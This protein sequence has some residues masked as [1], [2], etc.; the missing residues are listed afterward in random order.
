MVGMRIW[1]E[2]RGDYAIDAGSRHHL[3][4]SPSHATCDAE[5]AATAICSAC[6]WDAAVAPSLIEYRP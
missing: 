1:W 4:G 6:L 3:V 5:A 2:L